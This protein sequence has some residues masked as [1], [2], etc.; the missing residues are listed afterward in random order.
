MG[1]DS[2][3]LIF[4]LRCK[5]TVKQQSP[6]KAVRVLGSSAHALEGHLRTH[7]CQGSS[8][9]AL[10]FFGALCCL[11]QGNLGG[12]GTTPLGL[13]KM[14]QVFLGLGTR[15][16]GDLE[17]FRRGHEKNNPKSLQ[18]HQILR[19]QQESNIATSLPLIASIVSEKIKASRRART[20]PHPAIS[21]F[22]KFGVDPFFVPQKSL[23]IEASHGRAWLT[24]VELHVVAI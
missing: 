10:P 12:L 22:L 20:T 7:H 6:R 15:G 5:P 17:L 13:G 24:A 1:S 3:R 21:L 8:V 16:L 2:R 4:S 11:R 14:F 23:P 9:H 18:C 19:L